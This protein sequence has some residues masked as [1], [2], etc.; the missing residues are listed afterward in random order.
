MFVYN[1]T[2]NMDVH[3]ESEV[4]VWIKE[5][6]IPILMQNGL[7]HEFQLCKLKF[8]DQETPAYAIQLYSSHQN[9]MDEMLNLDKYQL[10]EPVQDRF[11]IQV[12]PFAS[13]LD[14]IEPAYL[15]FIHKN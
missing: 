8:V 14:I 2:L 13:I 4:V 1:I 15:S 11:G 12:M 6:Y 5:V 10:L 3:I 9:K 7:F